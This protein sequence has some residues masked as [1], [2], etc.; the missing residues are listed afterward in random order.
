M[1]GQQDTSQQ[2]ISHPVRIQSC[3]HLQKWSQTEVEYFFN[4]M[5]L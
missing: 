1:T 5:E 4:V 2:I 3:L